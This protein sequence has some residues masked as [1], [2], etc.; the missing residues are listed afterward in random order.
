MNIPKELKV[1]LF[2]GGV[3]VAILLIAAYCMEDKIPNGVYTALISL[4][5]IATTISATAI[6]HRLNQEGDREKQSEYQQNELKKTLYLDAAEGVLNLL[7]Y[8]VDFLDLRLTDDQHRAMT[9]N[10]VGKIGKAYLIGNIKTVDNLSKVWECFIQA[11][12]EL[13]VSKLTFYLELWPLKN[14]DV[15]GENLIKAVGNLSQLKEN[16]IQ[17]SP[18]LLHSMLLHGRHGDFTAEKFN[19]LRENFLQASPEKKDSILM[20]NSEILREIYD[21]VTVAL[22]S[23]E[24]H[25]KQCIRYAKTFSEANF[26]LISSMR[27]ELKGETIPTTRLKEIKKVLGDIGENFDKEKLK[28]FLVAFQVKSARTSYPTTQS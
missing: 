8:I 22:L 1:V 16:F 4:V 10:A 19:Q 13:S 24:I 17:L 9:K 3:S 2:V 14:K 21:N 25:L 12:T 20:D 27:D 18:E 28:L 6:N 11:S 15:T 26:E 7:H 5:G 23:F